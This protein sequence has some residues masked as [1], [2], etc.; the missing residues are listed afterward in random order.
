M[1]MS[2]K[3]LTLVFTDLKGSTSLKSE[4]G[5]DAA[6]QLI[7]RH[8]EHVKRLALADGGR[9]IDWAGDGCF[10]TFETPS[11]AVLFALC[12]Q[13]IHHKE[14]DLPK[15][16]TGINMGEVTE[17]SGPAG[18]DGP[19]RVEGLA[20][21]TA[22]RI[23]SLALPGQILMSSAVFNSARQRLSSAQIDVPICWE[24]HGAYLFKDF[25]EFIPIGEVG[26]EGAAPLEPP[27]GN[28][29]VQRAVTT[30]EEDTLGWRPATGLAIP[31][32][33]DWILMSHL[34]T[35]G[36]G[37]IWLATN[38]NT[39]AQHVFK[40]C[41][42]ADR[43]K[44]LKREVVL[45]RLLKESLGDRN[46]IARVVGWELDQQPFY[47]ESEYTSGGDLKAWAKSQG[48]LGSVPLKTRLELMAQT[49]DALSAAHK[50]GVLHKD[51]KP[52]NILIQPSD[53]PRVP[54]AV[55]ADFG[56]GL[57]TDLESLKEKDITTMGLTQTLVGSSSTAGSG[58][59]M[60]M[61][62]ELLE[63]KLPTPQSD[64]YS[65][66]VLLYQMVISDLSRAFATGWENNVEDELLR[67]D[68]A[69]CVAGNPETRLSDPSQLSER[70]RSLNERREQLDAENLARAKEQEAKVRRQRTKKRLTIAGVI[71][72]ILAI[73]AVFSVIH[74]QNKQQEARKTWARETAM[75][76]I[77]ELL[78][79]EEYP[80]AYN[81]IK[82]AQAIIPDD[83]VV[84]TYMDESTNDVTIQTEPAGARISYKPYRDF[85]GPWIDLGISPLNKVRIPVGMHRWRIQKE[86]YQERELA[87]AVMPRKGL[88]PQQLD[89]IAKNYGDPFL[90]DWCLYEKNRVPAGTIG[91][92]KGRFQMALVGFPFDP[93]GIAL[94]RFFID[95]TEVTNRE[96]KEFVTKGGYQDPIFWKEPFKKDAGVV[97]WSEAMKSFVDRT[98]QA[99]PATW[100]LGDYPEGQ[101]DYPVSGVSWYEAAAYAEFRS[102]S[103]PTIFHWVRS[104]LSIREVLAPMTHHIISQSNLGSTGLAKVGEYPG[105]GSSGVKD[106]AGN[107]RE[108]CWNGTGDKHYCL[109]GM[110]RDASY[111]FNESIALSAWDRSAE[112]G[113]RCAVYPEDAA[114]SKELLRDIDLGFYDPYSVPPFP[115]EVY[116]AKKA[117]YAYPQIPLDP[118]IEDETAAGRGWKR[119]KV[120][121]NAAYNKERLILRLDLPTTGKP[122]Y[123]AVIYFPSINAWKQLEFVRNP[124]W[125]PWDTI[126]RSGRAFIMPSYSG[127]F[128]RG[129]GSPDWI[130][131]SFDTWISEWIQD[132][133]RTIDY[134][135]TRKDI[136]TK[137]VALLGLS[138]GGFLGP[139]LSSF[140]DRIKVLILVGG[141]LNFSKAFPKPM[142]FSAP[143][144]KSPTLML[145]GKYDFVFPV[146]THQKPMLD[147]IGTPPEHKRHVIFEAGHLPLPRAEMLKEIL[148]WLDKYQGPVNSQEVDQEKEQR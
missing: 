3:V 114:P 1:H 75:P 115:K 129:G 69:A 55:L 85:E 8:R 54:Q 98:G 132:L 135:E 32:R 139:D 29:K 23:Q 16:Y 78:E 119:E 68:I 95:R 40:F 9:I 140:V 30:L 46:D 117:M 120:S 34:G 25:D 97:P 5:D 92:D 18:K 74:Y 133:G 22:A 123:K 83:P 96:Y 124:L 15:V 91:V 125:E 28:K 10:L 62:P 109:G 90:F 141:G 99:G 111:M 128:E 122:P 80:A 59:A 118:M 102:K 79:A 45:L 33:P 65:L 100:E 11:A 63:G 37:E 136:D 42:Q 147:L 47:I 148:A 48:G 64:I 131:K 31:G 57:L 113:F 94:E 70:L 138:L 58:T 108:W 146:E 110:W 36:F 112:N 35:G 20:V 134:L 142:G 145:N 130:Y 67:E 38:A 12:L 41:F 89:F 66:G 44:G 21:D 49:A 50:A 88:S 127:A 71:G 76:E 103:L 137:D 24:A 93:I 77:Q 73:T 116:L 19:P 86:G 27:P 87:R 14:P 4:K 101:D 144:A 105:I 72:L 143:Y 81:L 39:S 60:Y 26:I 7:A 82:K 13:Q 52:G 121:I 2:S 106:M 104:A 6:G 43:V 56:I 17:H 61:A 53:D 126:P 51:I 84:K 107:V